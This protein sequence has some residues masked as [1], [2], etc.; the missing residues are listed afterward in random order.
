MWPLNCIVY[1]FIQLGGL[2]ENSAVP[3][4]TDILL[5]QLCH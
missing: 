2:K 3:Y 1:S 5:C 4:K